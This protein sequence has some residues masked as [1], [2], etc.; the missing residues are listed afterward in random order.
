[1]PSVLRQAA[2]AAMFCLV[3]PAEGASVLSV[4]PRTVQTL[5]TQQLFD[6]RGRWYLI[7][8][9][10]CF[11]Y[12]ESPHTH[13]AAERLVLAAHLVSRLGQ[14][15]GST[16]AGADFAS[17]VTLSGKLRAAAEHKLIL[18]DIRIDRVDDES[19]RSAIALAL[20][21]DPQALPRSVSVDVLELARGQL[22]SAQGTGTR[23]EN[24]RIS[25]VTT[26]IDALVIEFE[27]NLKAP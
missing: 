17:N 3:I 5:V 14:S 15:L 21:V 7:S 20:Q 11:T 10:A 13:F 24:L 16:C 26:R 8:D 23:V 2:F 9:G 22:A 12:L 4:G 1:M 27:V 18:D 6:R 19:T 25:N